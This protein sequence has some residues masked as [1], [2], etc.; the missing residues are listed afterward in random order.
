[1]KLLAL[2]CSAA[3]ASAALLEDGKVLASSFVHVKQTHSKTLLPMV[4][5][6]LSSASVGIDEIDGLAVSTGP[7]SFT[8]IRIGISAVKG[9]A[10]PR[11]LPCA[12]VSTLLSMSYNVLNENAFICAVMDARCGQV[13]NALFEI[14]N[15]MITRVCEDRAVSCKNLAENVKKVSQNGNKRVIIIGDGWRVFFPYVKNL[16]GISLAPERLLYQNAVSVGLAAIADFECGN[17]VPPE[18]L[19]PVYLRL[20]QAE[21]ERNKK[22]GKT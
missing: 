17:T 19:L 6:V 16:P 9:L 13:Y 7:G 22:E 8:G 5:A 1:M 4:E 10:A 21:R 15:G 3:P 12:G 11:S 14:V 2:E 20:P 18:G